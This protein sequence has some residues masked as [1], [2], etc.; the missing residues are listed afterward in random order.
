M[1]IRIPGGSGEPRFY[2]DPLV[3]FR[4]MAD[5]PT[6]DPIDQAHFKMWCRIA[7]DEIEALTSALEEVAASKMPG[8]SRAIA[9]KALKARFADK[10]VA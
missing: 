4:A 1:S 3:R 9:L 8:A 10:G 7:A 5:S 2:G 6:S